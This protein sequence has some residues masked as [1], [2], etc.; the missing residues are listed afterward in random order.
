MKESHLTELFWHAGFFL[1]LSALVIPML[2]YFKIP[3]ALGYLFAGIAMGPYGLGAL[4]PHLPVFDGFSLKEAEHVKI[5]A[6]LGIVLLLF[7]IGLELTPRR[8]WQMRSLVFGLG[9]AQVLIT[10]SL[11]GIIAFW[12]DNAVEVSVLLG[13]SLA[14]SST[15]IVTQWLHEQKLFVT[16]VGRTSFSILL[17]QDLAVIPIL[18][19]LTVLSVDMNENI[20]EFVSLSLL[21]MGVTVVAIYFVGKIILKPVFVFANTH[22]GA[23]VFMALSLLIIVVSASIASYAGLSM[24]LGAFIAGLILADTEYRHEIS[25]LIVPFK[26][27]LLGI[28][29][30]SFGMG[31]NLYFIATKPVWLFLSVIGLMVMKAAIIYALCK[32]WKLPT[33]V[34]AESSILLSQAGEFGL[35]VVGSALTAGLMAENVGQFMLITVGM[36]MLLTPIIE[37]LARKVGIYIENKNQDKSD[38]DARNAEEKKQHIVI[39]GFGR[40]G[41]TVGDILSKEGFQILG[42]DRSIE[43]V[44]EARLKSAP[45]YLG[46]VARKT[47]Y[48]AAQLDE[49]ICVVITIDDATITKQIVKN[50]RSVNASIPIVVRAHNMDDVK[51]FSTMEKVEAIAEHMIVGTKLSEKVLL[52]CGYKED[53]TH[54]VEV[55][56]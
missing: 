20:V 44:H 17:F 45:V 22:G 19:L 6:E 39:F 43:R 41:R 8:L 46:N 40:V 51:A 52:H 9:G 42:F 18:L 1:A 10:A 50:L 7:V 47:T 37:P 26:S 3:V 24:A 5:L 13:L 35:L 54:K 56:A 53:E 23:E 16:H 38:Y 27:M 21:K 4:A 14:L 28:F 36:T 55:T 49:A 33:A 34:A 30:L 11:I 29:F 31:I 32:L 48:E 25:S 15:A 2:R 12:W